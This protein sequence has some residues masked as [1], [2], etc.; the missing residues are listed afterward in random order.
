VD[1]PAPS[2]R[3]GRWRLA[4][5]TVLVA[6]VAVVALVTLRLLLVALAPRSAGSRTPRGM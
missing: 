6:L 5:L 2:R 1:A 3:L 4:V